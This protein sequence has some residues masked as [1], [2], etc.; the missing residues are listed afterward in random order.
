MNVGSRILIFL[1]WSREKS[2]YA[3]SSWNLL[4]GKSVVVLVFFFLLNNINERNS[5]LY[6]ICVLFSFALVLFQPST[7][8]L[9]VI[10]FGIPD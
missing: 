3:G 10:K 9:V 6:F 1:G 4:L 8:I 5:I 7:N 2:C